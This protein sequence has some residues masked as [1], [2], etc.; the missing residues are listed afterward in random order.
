[1]PE[2]PVHSIYISLQVS[3]TSYFTED[4]HTKP[5]TDQVFLGQTG[6]T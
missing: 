5:G 4:G 2:T 3:L 1:M 6:R